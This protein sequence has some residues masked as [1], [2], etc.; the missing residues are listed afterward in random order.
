MGDPRVL[1]L[2]VIDALWSLGRVPSDL[3]PDVAGGLL[4]DGYDTPSLRQLAGL[5]RTDG[6]RAD[7]LFAQAIQELQLPPL[8]P[9]AAAILVGR[10]I[11]SEELA[12]DMAPAEREVPGAPDPPG[13]PEDLATRGRS[14][15][16]DR[17]CSPKRRAEVEEALL[18]AARDLLRNGA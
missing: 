18:S 15:E 2:E 8:S 9:L 7:E 14:H 3:M 5:A 12:R 11:A 16:D 13:G 6:R 17:R 4:E 10:H 1:P